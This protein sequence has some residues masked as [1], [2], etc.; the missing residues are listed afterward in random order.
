M[1]GAVGSRKSRLKR[2]MNKLAAVLLLM[3][4]ASA[5]VTISTK[6]TW[7]REVSR[8]VYQRC[9]SCHRT[10]GTA[11]SIPLA[12][13]E[14]SRPWATAIKE[15]VLNRQMPPW[16]AVKGFGEFANDQGLTQDEINLIAEWAEGGAPEGDPALLPE[17]PTEFAAAPLVQGTP[18]AIAK[19]Y[20][21]NAATIL[22]ALKAGAPLQVIATLPSGEVT[23]LLWVAVPLKKAQTFVLA[24]PVALPVGSTISATGPVTAYFK[25]PSRRRQTT[26]YSPRPDAQ[27]VSTHGAGQAS[28]K[29]H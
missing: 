24:S 11:A 29:S 25:A 10:G 17:A 20:R 6:I 26:Q 23:P 18:A 28:G 13:Y 8:I 2:R 1:T 14:Q 16:G 3:L 4:P 27:T 21:V 7:S 22:T 12:T 5:H 9:L 15:M 19:S